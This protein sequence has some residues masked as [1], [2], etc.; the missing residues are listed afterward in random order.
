M[1]KVSCG[2]CDWDVGLQQG[3][4]FGYRRRQRP[5]I[6]A[7]NCG[8]SMEERKWE[9]RCP[10]SFG[11]LKFKVHGGATGSVILCNFEGQF[12]LSL[13]I[14]WSLGLQRSCDFG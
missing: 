9:K 4:M 14:L 3:R 1:S 11:V 6:D 2:W 8:I 13:Q 7:S 12:L 10:P 5:F